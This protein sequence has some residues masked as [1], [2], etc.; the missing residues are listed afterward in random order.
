MPPIQKAEHWTGKTWPH[1]SA[2]QK[3]DT[4]RKCQSRSRGFLEIQ[5]LS[6]ALGE[7]DDQDD[8]RSSDSENN[9]KIRQVP[10]D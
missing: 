5:E 10:Q 8:S 9:S 3:E 4:L 7:K 6:K 1:L 2:E